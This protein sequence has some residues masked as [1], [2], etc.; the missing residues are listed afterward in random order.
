MKDNPDKF[1]DTATEKRTY[2][3]HTPEFVEM[4]QDS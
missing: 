2:I 4:D 1:Q 3:I